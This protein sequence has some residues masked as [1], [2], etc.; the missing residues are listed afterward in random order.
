MDSG[1]ANFH[2]CQHEQLAREMP[3][4]ASA[5]L[6]KTVD[7]PGHSLLKVRISMQSIYIYI[8]ISTGGFPLHATMHDSTRGVLFSYIELYL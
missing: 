2:P 4:A 1:L 3:T 8:Y 5:S 6:I 7:T